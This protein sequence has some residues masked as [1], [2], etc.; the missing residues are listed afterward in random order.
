MIKQED[1]LSKINMQKELI[2]VT[3]IEHCTLTNCHIITSK[4]NNKTKKRKHNDLL[5]NNN[6]NKKEEK[7]KQISLLSNEIM[8]KIIAALDDEDLREKLTCCLERKPKYW[9]R[10]GFVCCTNVNK[11]EEKDINNNQKT[12]RFI[13]LKKGNDKWTQFLQT[14]GYEKIES[15]FDPNVLHFV[16]KR[17]VCG[18]KRVRLDGDQNK[19]KVNKR[20][21]IVLSTII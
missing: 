4:E 9:D 15:E 1:T 14:I 11:N 13:F 8:K 16:K 19:H 17:L 20:Q 6:D 18:S 10:G 3:K 21:F 12:K 5:N 2:P 7:E